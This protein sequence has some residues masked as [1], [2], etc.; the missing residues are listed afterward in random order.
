MPSLGRPY[1][2]PMTVPEALAIIEWETGSHFDLDL[3]AEYRKIASALHSQFNTMRPAAL[4]DELRQQLARI[5]LAATLPLVG[6]VK[7]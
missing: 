6:P 2:E 1:K 4:H 7:H 5:H 3:V